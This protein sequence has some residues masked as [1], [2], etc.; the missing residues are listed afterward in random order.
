MLGVC[1]GAQLVSACCCCVL[2]CAAGP[3]VLAAGEA[4]ARSGLTE[5]LS[6]H[7]LA[8]LLCCVILAIG[9]QQLVS[10]WCCCV[11]LFSAAG[12]EVL[13]AG[14]TELCAATAAGLLICSLLSGPISPNRGVR[15]GPQRL[16]GSVTLRSKT[17]N[18]Q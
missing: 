8:L 5:L 9:V 15:R 17:A 6:C 11:V 14:P 3:E 12:P 13:A 10:A 4:E 16:G 2:F 1:V 7:R 18:P